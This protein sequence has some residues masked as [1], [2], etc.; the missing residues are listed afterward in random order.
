MGPVEDMLVDEVEEVVLGRLDVVVVGG[1]PFHPWMS[2][3]LKT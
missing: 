2:S 1:T 3:Q